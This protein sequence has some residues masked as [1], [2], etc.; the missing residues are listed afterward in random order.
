[1]KKLM[2]LCAAFSFMAATSTF[3]Q[4]NTSATADQDKATQVV[5][6]GSESKSDV[7][8]EPSATPK[9]CC[10][11]GSSKSCC[12]DKSKASSKSC[13]HDHANADKANENK[14]AGD[15]NVQP[16]AVAPSDLATPKK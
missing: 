10:K 12:K 3:A 2:L 1:M 13:S 7:S 8:A 6:A 15:V 4:S 14:A 11:A 9:S 16:S 5:P